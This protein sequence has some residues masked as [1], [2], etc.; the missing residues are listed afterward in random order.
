MLRK[1]R[2]SLM[3]KRGDAGE[4]GPYQAD[5]DRDL[6]LISAIRE[7]Q[8]IAILSANIAM[9]LNSVYRSNTRSIPMRVA[10]F[11]PPDPVVL[12]LLLQGGWRAKQVPEL[13]LVFADLEAAKRLL[14]PYITDSRAPIDNGTL[15]DLVNAWKDATGSILAAFEMFENEPGVRQTTK[16]KSTISEIKQVLVDAREGN[17]PAESANRFEV[18]AW[19]RRRE[20]KRLLLNANVVAHYHGQSRNAMVTDVSITGF[21]LSDAPGLRLG[22]RASV[23][24]AGGRSLAGE[25]VW[26]SQN[27]AGVKLFAELSASDPLVSNG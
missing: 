9:F 7:L 22:D 23:T 27:R 4:A 21:S 14:R 16:L 19:S 26:I 8:N 24:L 1:A 10:A 13:K 15:L 3:S 2:L 5:H 25:V 18:S 12:P 17:V 11:M 20:H 6:L